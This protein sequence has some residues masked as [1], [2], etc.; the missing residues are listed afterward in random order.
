MKENS[1]YRNENQHLLMEKV[2]ARTMLTLSPLNHLYLDCFLIVMATIF[3]AVFLN[4]SEYG[5]LGT[6]FFIIANILTFLYFLEHYF[7]LSRE[8]V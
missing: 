6:L 5:N 4:Y 2:N 3:L 1:R 7:A 8:E